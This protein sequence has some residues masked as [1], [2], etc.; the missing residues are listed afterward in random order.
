MRKFCVGMTLVAMSLFGP[1]VAQDQFGLQAP[2]P[3][4]GIELRGGILSHSVDE[5]GDLFGVFNVERFQDIN[6][7]LLFDVPALN[8]WI[9][10]GEF[11]PHVGATINTG[12]LESMM[13]A[14]MSWTVPLGDTP[15]FFEASLGGAVHNGGTTGFAAS[16]PARDLGCTLLFRESATLGMK[17]SD[18]ASVM[19]TAEHASNA[20]L[21]AN[22]R[23]MTNLGIRFGLQF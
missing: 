21:C 20:N 22:N 19:I 15:L 18:N 5:P 1:A 4:L 6:V 7:E 10:W 16:Y 14:G 3:K 8:T 13:Y 12:G 17:V 11:R 23:G 9:A 2:E